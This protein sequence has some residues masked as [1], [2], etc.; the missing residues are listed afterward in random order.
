MAKKDSDQFIKLLSENEARL[1]AYVLSLI[2]NW[3]E[4]DEIAQLVRIRLW[5]QFA[6]YDP[7]KDF[8]AWSRAIAYHLVRAHWSKS[9]RRNQIL[10]TTFL[11]QVSET[12]VPVADEARERREVLDH[13]L[14]KLSSANRR[15]L[16]SYYAE[17]NKRRQLAEQSNRTFD[18]LRQT[19]RRL[20]LAIAGCV[21]EALA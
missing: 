10:S 21:R 7:N 17:P 9:N 16:Q 5:E 19:V 6:E 14:G 12:F 8:G 2:P 1:R 11:Q 4:A 3:T 18:S 15:I 13:C 20:R